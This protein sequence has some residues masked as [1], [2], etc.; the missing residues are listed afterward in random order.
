MSV[1]QVSAVLRVL[2]ATL[3]PFSLSLFLLFALLLP[4]PPSWSP[5][6]QS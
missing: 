5:G 3:S 2:S 4:S 1:M 6:S